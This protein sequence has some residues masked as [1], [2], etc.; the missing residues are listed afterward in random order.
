[1]SRGGGEGGG[2]QSFP[3]PAACPPSPSP[4]SLGDAAGERWTSRVAMGTQARLVMGEEEGSR[5][6]VRG[7]VPSQQG[8]SR[9]GKGEP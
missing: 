8:H 2:L 3:R 6:R 9:E 1:M 7:A 4:V 5:G